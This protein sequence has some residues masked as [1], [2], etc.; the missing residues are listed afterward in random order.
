MK[1]G[2]F[3]FDIDWQSWWKEVGR[4]AELHNLSPIVLYAVAEAEERNLNNDEIRDRVY[5]DGLYDDKELLQNK[6][7]DKYREIFNENLEDKEKEHLVHGARLAPIDGVN[8]IF[9]GDYHGDQEI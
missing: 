7:L 4:I 5:E 3:E 8:H 6:R 9:L 2:N 1:L